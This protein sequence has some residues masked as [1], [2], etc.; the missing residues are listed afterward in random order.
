MFSPMPTDLLIVL[1]LIVL[2]G[3][4]AMSEIA[5]VSAKRA[6]LMQLADAGGAGARRALQ[7]QAEP[8]RFLSS[9]Q[10]GITSIGILNGAIGESAIAGRLR[11]VIESVPDLV[12]YADTLALV[13]MVIGLTYVSLIVGELVPKRLALTHPERIASI[14]ARPMQL[15]AT[16]G[17]PLVV[18]LSAS[19]DAILRLLRVRQVKSPAVTMEEIKV[20]LE[21]G[22]EEGVFEPTEHELVTNVL[23]LD[24]RRVGAVLTPRSDI[25][26]LN[27]R[28]TPEA[29][30]AKLSGD[31]HAVLPVCDGE[32]DNVIGFVRVTRVLE[33]VLATGGFD[34]ASLAEP[35]LFVPETMTVMK[36]LEQFKRTHLPVA[37]V[38]G[39]FG[40]IEGLVSMT[41][42]LS[43]IVGDLPTEPGEEPSIVQREDG[44]WL[45]DGGLDLPTVL[46]ALDAESLL[47][48]PDL[49]QYHT[50]GG[51][52]MLALGRIPK[53]G[54]VFTKGDYRFEIVDMD[55][56]RVDRVLVSR[57]GQ[58]PGTGRGL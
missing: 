8:T 26:F 37:L 25:A 10:V 33:Q 21:Q 13:G 47:R 5:I 40:D 44:T 28:D 9:V 38:V 7:L 57:A 35:P 12:P 48:D 30:R 31:L 23:G 20:L 56:N 46:Q 27:V 16:V 1:V 11:R 29:N 41:D 49:R 43:A 51:L 17:R 2:N 24:E 3:L 36:L 54:N 15:I 14:I 34:L 18:L 52:A 32:L 45:I 22:T 50:L 4:F 53:T 19:T 39:E 42:V 58:P 6:R 55:G